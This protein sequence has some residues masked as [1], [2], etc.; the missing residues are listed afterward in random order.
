[1]LHLL[2]GHSRYILSLVVSCFFLSFF[3]QFSSLLDV[4]LGVVQKCCHPEEGGRKDSGVGV[5]LEWIMSF[6]TLIRFEN[7]FSLFSNSFFSSYII[8]C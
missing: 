8:F 1:M 7:D 4:F 6:L 3:I 5:G 2:T